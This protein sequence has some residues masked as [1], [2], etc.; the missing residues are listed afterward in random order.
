MARVDTSMYSTVLSSAGGQSACVRPRRRLLL[1][2]RLPLLC[3]ACACAPCAPLWS[4]RKQPLPWVSSCA[5]CGLLE[6]SQSLAMSKAT[7]ATLTRTPAPMIS[8]QATPA[9]V[10]QVASP[11]RPRQS[12]YAADTGAILAG[13][14]GSARSGASASKHPTA[15][16][17]LLP[18]PAIVPTSS[19]DGPGSILGVALGSPCAGTRM[20]GPSEVELAGE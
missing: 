15:P 6:K 4:P 16:G 8:A 3:I 18:S 5:P 20:M 9:A 14:A 12:I 10:L 7:L 1:R 11:H 19:I 2:E 17:C 13:C